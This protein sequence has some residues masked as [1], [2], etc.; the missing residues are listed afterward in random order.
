[1]SPAEPSE[2]ARRNRE[3]WDNQSDDYDERNAK[4][5]ERGMAWGLWQIPEEELHVLGDIAGKDVL[6]LGCGAGD[7]CRSLL[8]A[9]GRPVGLDNSQARLDRARAGNEAAGVDFPLLH[10]SAEAIPPEEASFDVVMA[11]WGAPTFTDPYLFVPEVARILR[12]GG[13]FAFTGGTPLD[14]ITFDEAADTY[15]DR[16][17]R[18]YFGLHRWETPE[19]S[20]EFMLPMGEWIRLYRRSGFVV[21][22]LIEVQPPEGATSTYRSESEIEWARKWP[23]EQIW[24]VRRT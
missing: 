17:Q 18:T 10:A 22:D 12:P 9:G 14:W 8:R 4:F 19:G 7:W 21:E 13:L 15:S 23:M 11:D 1:M 3:F 16:L 20:V 5:I 2:D 6:D 24:K